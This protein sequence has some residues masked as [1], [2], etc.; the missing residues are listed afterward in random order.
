MPLANN[1]REV[2]NDETKKPKYY[3]YTKKE[4]LEHWKQR[5]LENRK[6]NFDIITRVL[7]F[8]PNDFVI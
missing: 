5:W 8:T 2:L 7:N 3:N 6:K 1:S 4:L